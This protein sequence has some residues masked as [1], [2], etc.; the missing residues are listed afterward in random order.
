MG[1][2]YR[3]SGDYLI[4]EISLPNTETTSIGKYGRMRQRYP[5]EHCRILYNAMLLDGTLWNHLAEVDETCKE[6]MDVLIL[7]MKEK[8]GITDAFRLR[9][10]GKCAGNQHGSG[11]DFHR[12]DG[13]LHRS[14]GD[15]R[16]DD[17]GNNRRDRR[18]VYAGGHHG[19]HRD[20][21]ESVYTQG[22]DWWSDYVYMENKQP[23]YWIEFDGEFYLHCMFRSDSTEYEEVVYTLY[24]DWDAPCAQELTIRTVKDAQENDISDWFAYLHFWFSYENIVFME[25]KRNEST[26]AGGPDNNLL[27]GD[28]VLLPPMVYPK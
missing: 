9:R 22:W 14:P 27:S 4:P 10:G 24:P 18:N 11:G 28:Y 25:V 21:G 7:G 8:H 13:D 20:H 3:Q 26:L 23:K 2:T 12:S 15:C 17:G 1:G 19:T 16:R 5:K 6:R